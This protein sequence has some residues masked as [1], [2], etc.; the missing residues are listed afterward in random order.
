MQTIRLSLNKVPHRKIKLN[1]HF[2]TRARVNPFY[3]MWMLLTQLHGIH[4]ISTIWEHFIDE[5]MK[6]LQISL[7]HF[8][9][10]DYEIDLRE[11]K[12]ESRWLIDFDDSK[13]KIETNFKWEFAVRTENSF[14][15]FNQM[16]YSNSARFRYWM[17]LQVFFQ[18]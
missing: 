15:Q 16:H 8:D 9:C 4:G 12:K 17:I 3:W 11:R 13:W 14:R 7:M 10:N 5:V 2:G 6:C 18:Y 1:I